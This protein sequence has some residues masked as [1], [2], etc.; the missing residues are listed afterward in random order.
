ML[1]TYLPG[2]VTALRT[3]CAQPVKWQR[4]DLTQELAFCTPTFT[5]ALVAMGKRWKQPIYPLKAEWLNK[6]W[7]IQTMKYYSALQR[8]E[9]LIRAVGRMHLEDIMLSE[10]KPDTGQMLNEPTYT[11]SLE[12]ANS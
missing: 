6:T 5:A 7:A 11:K 8:K 1:T 12:Q 4:K 10:F 9:I 2:P 3:V